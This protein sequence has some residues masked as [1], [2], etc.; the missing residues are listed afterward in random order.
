MAH[1]TSKLPKT[2]PESFKYKKPEPSPLVKAQVH[3]KK[4]DKLRK[5]DREARKEEGEVDPT[6][7]HLQF[8]ERMKAMVAA[9]APREELARKEFR[10][11]LGKED[12]GPHE[13]FGHVIATLPEARLKA[14]LSMKEIGKLN[15]LVLRPARAIQKVIDDNEALQDLGISFR[16]FTAKR[17]D[18]KFGL[19]LQGYKS[20]QALG[21]YFVI[22]WKAADPKVRKGKNLV[23]D[24]E[25]L[26]LANQILREVATHIVED[27]QVNKDKFLEVG[28]RRKIAEARGADLMARGAKKG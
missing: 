22:I 28:N 16:D 3:H 6:K 17:R 2:L 18:L 25:V 10:G 19:G 21:L 23:Q 14:I 7:P 26:D 13:I 15:A 9:M 24:V 1:R 20:S 11:K 27:M 5:A 12:I 4:A 8:L